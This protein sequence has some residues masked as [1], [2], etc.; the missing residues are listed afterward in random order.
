MA[1]SLE[2]VDSTVAPSALLDTVRVMYDS[3]DS[4]TCELIQRHLDAVYLLSGGKRRLIARLYNARWWSRESNPMEPR[5]TLASGRLAAQARRPRV[6][7]R[8]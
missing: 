3:D 1:V 4:I 7:N 6:R 2:C 8:V 5:A